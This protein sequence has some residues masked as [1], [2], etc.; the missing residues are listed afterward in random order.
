MAKGGGGGGS[1]F[2]IDLSQCHCCRTEASKTA[3]QDVHL[4]NQMPVEDVLGKTE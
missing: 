1:V 2:R 3:C 4:A